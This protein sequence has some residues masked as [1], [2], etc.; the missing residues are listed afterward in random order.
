MKDKPFERK[1]LSGGSSKPDSKRPRKFDS[2]N[3]RKV[4]DKPQR[5][6]GSRD[7]RPSRFEGKRDDRPS[8]FDGNRGSSDR[9]PTGDRPSRFDT[10][11][12]PSG[13]RPSRF[14]SDRKP[15][16]D[17]PSRFDSD[18]KPSGDRPSRFDSDRP[19]GRDEGRSPRYGGNNDRSF[20]KKPSSDRFSIDSRSDSNDRPKRF[21]GSNDRKPSGDR[22][23]R[24]DGKGPTS[25][26]KRDE[27]RGD[28]KRDDSRG[29]FKREEAR[30]NFKRDSSRGDFKRDEKGEFRRVDERGNF[31]R[32]Y[33]STG[34]YDSDN[35][36]GFDKEF[37]KNQGLKAK[38]E[39]RQVGPK[40]APNY[41]EERLKS[42]LPPKVRQKVEKNE[43][44][45]DSIRLNRYI[46]NAGLCSRREADE[47]IASGQITVNGKTI[48]EMGY[49]VQPSDVVKYGRKILNR[50]K[51]MYL[52]LNKPKDFIT[53]TD[54][55][56]GRRTVMELVNNACEERIYPVGRL[57]RATTGLLLMT[58]DGELA[59]KL[60]HPTNDIKKIYQVELDKPLTNE[61]FDQILLG[62]ELEDGIVK[63]D[64]LSAVTPDAEVIG[65]EIHSGK[66]RIVRRIFE[67]LGYEVLKLDRT[68]Y[69]GLTKKDL[70]RGKWRFLS[71]KEVI[72]LKYLI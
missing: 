61:H 16:G 2:D 46:A 15:S 42:H 21:E 68:T 43:S 53:T 12:K 58:N 70:P 25:G 60:S 5:F 26:F 67:S 3:T 1:N 48:S 34:R 41:S 56:E 4:S 27:S 22:P 49:Q 31:K 35:K 63:A 36:P 54:D 20:D 29:G 44:K 72:R 52:L 65:I 47:F 7:D 10:D 17:R 28:F 55:P 38:W 40:R 57:D 23:S 6:E 9:K 66:N 33:P 62:V 39:D 14:D 13:D 64:E 51:L 18:R 37:S 45:V 71:E 32:D 8:K 19:K 30:G 24:F 59:D 50:E 69:A 11:R